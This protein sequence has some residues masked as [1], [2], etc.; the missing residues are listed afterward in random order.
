M[1]LSPVQVRV[2]G[3][4]IEKE[5]ATPENYPL[6]MNGLLAAC[7]QST[8]RYPVVN[9]NEPTVESALL[10]LRAD[11][12][13]RVVHSR[14][15]RADRYRHVLDEALALAEAELA[16]L[17][18]LMLRG[19]QTAAELRTRTERL[20][21]FADQEEVERVLDALAG[22]PEPL[23]ARLGR[24]PGQK[25]PRWAHLLGGEVADVAPPVAPDPSARSSRSER[26]DA[27]ESTVAV[28]TA[29]LERL[30]TEHDALAAQLRSLLS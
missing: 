27:L 25:E 4:L 7:N 22:R 23:V 15:N 28:L 13:L 18:V 20:H 5:R 2:L 21:R 8:S 26:L 17:G 1:E 11:G 14:S 19:S 30:R 9:L 16:V 12:L 24:A 6:T 10:N 3:S 29:E